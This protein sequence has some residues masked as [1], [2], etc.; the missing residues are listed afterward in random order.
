MRSA[1]FEQLWAIAGPIIEVK[2]KLTRNVEKGEDMKKT[3][4]WLVV[5]T[6]MAFSASALSQSRS[7]GNIQTMANVADAGGGGEHRS[8]CAGL[9]EG[10]F[11]LNCQS[12]LGGGEP[13]P[14]LEGTCH[15]VAI[16][17]SIADNVIDPYIPV[18]GELLC[19][20]LRRECLRM[21]DDGLY[22]DEARLCSRIK[23]N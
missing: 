17:P 18:D 22:D 11:L 4:V 19:R 20:K 15:C 5:A 8:M 21:P 3:M 10:S 1:I 6:I 2:Q 16:C 13:V 9:I 23:G 14:L 7:S 12:V